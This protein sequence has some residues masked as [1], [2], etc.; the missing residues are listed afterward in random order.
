[1]GII[2]HT[3]ACAGLNPVSVFQ[4]IAME[5]WGQF[6]PLSGATSL[7]SIIT[8]VAEADLDK[9]RIK[10][11]VEEGIKKY[12]QI[13]KGKRNTIRNVISTGINSENDRVRVLQELLSTHDKVTVRTVSASF[14]VNTTSLTKTDVEQGIT[15]LKR[16]SPA[17]SDVS[18]IF[19]S[20]GFSSVPKAKGSFIMKRFLIFRWLVPKRQHRQHGSSHGS[21]CRSKDCRFML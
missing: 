3:V 12:K 18:E 1:M 7:P 10:S 9:L 8:G 4:K 16:T 15:S 6:L 20:I 21:R 11:E 17:H 14:A 2:I 19:P 13:L 5:T